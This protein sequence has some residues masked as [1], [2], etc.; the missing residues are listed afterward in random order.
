MKYEFEMGGIKVY[1]DPNV[2]TNH[3]GYYLNNDTWR[4]LVEIQTTQPLFPPEKWIYLGD[5]RWKERNAQM[6]DSVPTPAAGGRKDDTNK[7]RVDLVPPE[8]IEAAAR[9]FGFG[10]KKYAAWNWAKGMAWLRLYGAVLRH[11]FAWLGR[12][13]TDPESGLSHLDHALA[14]LMMLRAHVA[15]ALGTDDRPTYADV[16]QP[17]K[18]PFPDVGPCPPGTTVAVLPHQYSHLDFLK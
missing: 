18:L 8:G 3:P 5:N 4:P 16:R 9:A 17:G 13:E 12:E 7:V 1:S 11:M 10:E 2:P 15:R 6:S 14:S